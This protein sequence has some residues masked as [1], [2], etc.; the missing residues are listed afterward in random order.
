MKLCVIAAA[1][2]LLGLGACAGLASA[3]GAVTGAPVNTAL[4]T[5]S[6]AVVSGSQLTV[7][8]GSWDGTQPISFAYQWQRCDANGAACTDIAAATAQQYLLGASDV[9][10]RLRVGVGASNATGSAAVLTQPSG[11]VTAPVT[12]TTSQQT[13]TTVGRGN[14]RTQCKHD[15]W[16]TFT[17]PV[18]RN[19]GQCV[20]FFTHGRHNEDGDDE[21]EG[22]DDGGAGGKIKAGGAK[23]QIGGKSVTLG[24]GAHGHPRARKH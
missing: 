9:G 6:G 14:P 20:G 11:L 4:P 18:F 12:P 21:D 24:G 5:I 8:P 7:S 16:R 17:N 19:Q 15:R 23:I 1:L 13:T 10:H 3:R 2:C 22:D